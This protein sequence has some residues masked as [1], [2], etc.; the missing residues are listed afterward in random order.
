VAGLSLFWSEARLNFPAALYTQPELNWDSIYVAYIPRVIA[1]KGTWDYYRVL[2][3]FCALLRDS[4]TTVSPPGPLLDSLFRRPPM[5]TGLIEGNVIILDISQPE[6]GALGLAVGDEIDAIDG[7][8]TRQ[9]AETHVY[10][11]V[12]WATPQDRETRMYFYELLRGP[13]GVP[14]RIT[15]T[16]ARGR[17]RTVAVPRRGY[18][19]VPARLVE[20]RTLPGNIG[21]VALNSF[22]D[23]AAVPQFDSAMAQLG[24]V[25]GLVLD[26]RANG[27]GNSSVGYDILRRLAT[28]E[29]PTSAMWTRLYRAAPRAWGIEPGWYRM[30]GGPLRPHESIHH[31]MAVAVLIGPRT[32]SA[33]EDFAVAFDQMGRGMMIG[34]ATG[35]NTGQPLT[36]PLPG[37]GSARIRTKHDAYADGREFLGV[38]VLPQVVVKPTLAG[39]RAG[40]DEVLEEAVR[41][42]SASR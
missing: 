4:H 39:I 11:T 20:S 38:G 26:L 29:S 42:L 8:P 34:E 33:A 40:R 32:F 22:N 14:V 28:H 23:N 36:I 19:P 2:R 3:E 7:V 25:T 41:R 13:A 24:T 16:D 37:G 21:Y 15:V 10:P 9:Y 30:A 18:K 17:S 35:G 1:A 31:A 6:I 27:G 12:A 5:R